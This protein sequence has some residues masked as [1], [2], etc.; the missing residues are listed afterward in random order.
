LPFHI[1]T[2]VS[3]ALSAHG[4]EGAPRPYDDPLR[5]GVVM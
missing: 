3:G 2:R 5:L 1:N 4:I